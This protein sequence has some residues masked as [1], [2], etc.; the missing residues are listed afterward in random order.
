MVRGDE[1]VVVAAFAAWLRGDGW[2]VRTEVGS[3][4]VVAERD[5]ARLICEA[6]GRTSDPGTDLDTAYGQ[7]LRGVPNQD[8]PAVLFG[9]VVRDDPRSIRAALRVGERVRTLLRIT[10]YAVA[11]DGTVRTVK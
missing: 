5:G 8:D 1:A 7:L 6:K 11:D 2:S 9:L 4:D 3:A 10:L